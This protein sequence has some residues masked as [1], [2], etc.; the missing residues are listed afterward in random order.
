MDGVHEDIQFSSLL[1]D[2]ALEVEGRSEG[3]M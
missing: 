1:E 3:R 2:A